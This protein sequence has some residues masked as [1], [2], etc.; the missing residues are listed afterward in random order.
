MAFPLHSRSPMTKRILFA[1]ILLGTVLVPA[2]LDPQTSTEE[3]AVAIADDGQHHAPLPDE[4]PRQAPFVPCF[5]CH[6][7]YPSQPGQYPPPGTPRPL[8]NPGACA[9]CHVIP[10]PDPRD[11][12]YPNGPDPSKPAPPLPPGD[13]PVYCSNCHRIDPNAPRPR[14]G[15]EAA[16]DAIGF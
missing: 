2:C 5:Q 14:K 8:P 11:P 9:G 7:P 6:Q 15:A 1:A 10:G 3:S 4:P 13:G 16:V 12:H